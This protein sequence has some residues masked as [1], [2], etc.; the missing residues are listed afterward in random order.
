M[1]LNIQKFGL[2]PD[3]SWNPTDASELL[4]RLAEP[5]GAVRDA[6]TKEVDA[7]ESLA[8][9]W[10]SDNANKF[11]E[12]FV[13]AFNSFVDET[14]KYVNSI[15][16]AIIS[17]AETYS[18][19]QASGEFTGRWET[20]DV[21]KVS[22][23]FEIKD[24]AGRQGANTGADETFSN[25]T[26]TVIEEI[27]SALQKFE[28]VANSTSAFSTDNVETLAGTLNQ[29]NTKINNW[30]DENMLEFNRIASE[31][32]KSYIEANQAVNRQFTS[33]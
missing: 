12:L 10:Y 31:E 21:R 22:K 25:A 15:G 23:T 8:E 14:V 2:G 30:Q 11:G 29:I 32:I 6:L 27:K 9:N 13:P 24:S 3:N 17:A 28:D 18:G 16:T 7:L 19:V 4:E 5:A 26:T 1:K 33:Q 20:I